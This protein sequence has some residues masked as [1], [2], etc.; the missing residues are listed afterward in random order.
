[1]IDSI[2]DLLQEAYH[3]G[4]SDVHMSVGIPPIFRIHGKLVRGEASSLSLDTIESIAKKLM[5]PTE[6]KQFLST[7]EIDFSQ[8]FPPDFRVRFNVYRQRNNIGIAARMIPKKIPSLEELHLPQLL[9][10]LVLEPNGLIL[11][12]GPTGSGKS[13]TLAA[14][15]DYVNQREAKHIITLEDPIEYEHSHGKSI[16]HQREVG[17][18][19]KSFAAGLRASLRQDPDII[20]VGEMR[21]YETISTAITAAET[22]HLVLSTLHTNNAPETIHRI[23]DVFP[24]HQQNQVRIQLAQVLV[25]II[26]QQLL[27]TID[28]SGRVVATEVLIN[29]PSV[30]NLIRNEKV[31]QITNVMQMGQAKGMHTLSMSVQNLFQRGK[32]SQNIAKQFLSR[33]GDM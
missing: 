24:P 14:M 1:M 11:V 8:S 3:R 27:P 20:L 13:T 7:G 15:I 26:S 10:D 25:G 9:Q 17:V 28:G 19:T 16:I 30:A 5:S 2:E 22:G 31:D 6:W 21:D 29:Q 4:A 32:I 33:V 12:T 23:I 18:D